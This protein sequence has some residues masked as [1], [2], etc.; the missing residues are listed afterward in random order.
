MTPLFARTKLPLVI[1]MAVLALSLIQ[2]AHSIA[3]R[4]DANV[5][6]ANAAIAYDDKHYEEALE[7]LKQALA[8]DPKHER[9]LFYTGLVHLAQKNPSQAIPPLETVHDLQPT[10]INIQH[11]LGVAYFSNG[12]YDKAAPLLE[13]TFAQN[14]SAENLGYYVGFLRYRDKQYGKSVEAFDKNETSD[15]D[16]VQ[17]NAFYR[18]L[19]LGV[20]GL[21]GEALIELEQVQRTQTI[22]PLTQSSIRIREALSS[23]Q[24]FG[25]QKRFR[26]QINV[27]GF[28][29]DNVAINPDP[30]NTI[31][32]NANA[33]NL[34]TNL[35]NR[36]TTSP[37]FLASLRADYSFLRQGPFEAVATY[38]F[39]QT[40]YTE[41]NLSNFNIQDHQVGLS[42]F[43]RGVFADIPYQL[44]LQYF[45]DYLFLDMNGFLARHTPTASA[46]FVGPTFNLPFVGVVGNL[47]TLLYRYQVQ[48][49]F[50]EVGNNDVRFAGDL[51]DGYNNTLGFIHAFRLANDKLLLR[52][53]YQY[54][55]ESTDGAAFSYQGNRLLTGGQYQLP[56]GKMTLRYDYDVHWRDYKN[57]QTTAFF[58]NREGNLV[59]RDDI[60]QTHL[61]QLTKPLPNNFA[62]TAQYQGI[63]SQ[64]NIPLYDYTKNV[65]TLIFTYTY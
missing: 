49:F 45:Y 56:W 33:Q 48:T 30:V 38:S 53:G 7:L 47:T 19:A 58:T 54:D 3:Q 15:P 55:N 22:S 10:D 41:N 42:G 61:V 44:G 43:Y 1:F 6:A 37:G 50:R 26:L 8:L 57:T 20:L 2:P 23:G 24:I 64:S 59:A 13:A 16:T 21:P 4:S 27:G 63:R 9:S 62:V 51:R 14:P 11:H 65:W 29:D 46:T 17:L 34:I 12:N 25:N 40:V 31:I 39:F 28:Y 60:Q 36:H 35:R 5:L 52:L 32:P 18:G